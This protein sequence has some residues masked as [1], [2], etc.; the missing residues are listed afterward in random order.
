M[1][2]TASSGSPRVSPQL[3]DTLPLSSVRQAEQQDRFPKR[4]ELENLVTFFRSGQDRIE[5]S[6]II[7]ANAEAIVARAANRIFV[8]GTPLSFLEA[9]LSTG[10]S[11][12]PSGQEGTPLA[13]DQAAF[14]QSVRTFT[15]DSGS[16][17]RGNVLTRLLEGAGGDADVRVVLPTGFN[18][19]SVAKYG[20]AFMRKSVRDM[21]WF[22]RYVGYALVAGD[23]S[24]LSVNTRGLRDILLKN[25]SLTATNVA[26]QEMRAASAELLRDRPEARQLTID[27]FNVLL[28]E[29]AI[30]TPST[31]QRQGSSVQQGLQ[32]PAIYALAAEGRQRFEM[33]PGLSGAEKAEVVRAAYRQVFERDIAKGYSQTPCTVEA[34]QVAQG[35]I[36]MRE[37]IRALGRSKEYRQQFHDGFVNSRVVELAYRHFLGRG[38]SS[39]EEFRKS[40]AILSDQ[41]LNGLVDVLV[42]SSEYAQTF[43]EETVPFLRDLGTE[44]QESA[45]WGSNR[46][47]FNFSAPFNGAPQYITLYASYRQPFADQHVYGGGNDPVANQYGAIFP[48]GTAS[49][50]TRPAPYGY[51]SRRLLVS[52]GLNS[53][54]QLDTASFRNCRPRKV[55]PKVVRLQQIAT[56]GN[57][58]RRVTG[59]PSVRN[60]E[61]ST[62]AVINAV[63]VQILGNAGYAGERRGSDEA[64]LENG[65]ISLREFVR[66][67]ARSDAF[68]RRYWSGLYIVKA[69]EVMHRRLL[70]RPTFGRWEIDALFDTAARKGFYGVVDALINSPEYNESFGE[71]TVPF[72]RFITPSDVNARRAPGWR[73]PIDLIAVTNYTLGKRPD[74]RLSEQFRSS[75]DITPRNLSGSTTTI[76]GD[77]TA[78]ISDNAPDPRW[79]S[80]MPRQG[81]D[82]RVKTRSDSKPSR[83]DGPVWSAQLGRVRNDGSQPEAP[84]ARMAKALRT[85]DASGFKRRAGLPPA[86]ELKRPCTESELRVV[87]DATYRQLLNRVPLEG[88]RL[89]KAESRLRNQEIDLTGFVAE[90]AMGE[91]FQTRLSNMAPLRAA[92]AAGLALLGRATTPAE[93][94]RFLITRAEA[95]QGAA[96]SELLADRISTAVPSTDGMTSQ[97]GVAQATVQRTAALY[98]GNAGMNPPTKPA[99]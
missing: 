48:S 28:Q 61:S 44:A 37:F 97:V 77:W 52:N 57:V 89:V 87:L 27:C 46:K 13:A 3:F 67:V 99:I 69:I 50:A 83:L 19:I 30:P 43:G 42:N 64:R 75:G 60:T 70:G 78:N 8:G 38:I 93:T 9:P 1:T 39:L 4:V 65:D 66:C 82:P 85:A 12:R 24:I 17:K 76:R 81:F 20:P 5:A 88:E 10:E 94:S 6:R 74:A 31:K 96:V 41:G 16:T 14:E 11:G 32:L 71:D 29:L 84:D 22:L 49:V 62:Q 35:Q 56:G 63:Y 25:C 72:E 58:N 95:G 80:L 98:Q 79:A 90:V 92:S 33:R 2:V 18:A 21:G 26:L 51:D 40:F 73:Q 68:R 86:I 23:P 59:R 53:P 36:S 55:G 47:L 45:G 34:S 54:G 7:A 15:G 91:A